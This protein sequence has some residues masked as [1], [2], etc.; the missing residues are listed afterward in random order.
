MGL[1]RHEPTLQPSMHSHGNKS[2]PI[3]IF[4]YLKCDLLAT[5]KYCISLR[6]N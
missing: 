5:A 3:I 1:R 6:H 2:L 4:A